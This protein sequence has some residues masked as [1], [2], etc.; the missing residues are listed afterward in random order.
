MII[1]RRYEFEYNNSIQDSQA[2]NPELYN[3]IR[4]KLPPML[5]KYNARCLG[6]SNKINETQKLRLVSREYLLDGGVMKVIMSRKGLERNML[7]EVG[8]PLGLK[9]VEFCNELENLIA[10][11]LDEA[12]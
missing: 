1:Y 2:G 3:M 9:A 6:I 5:T 7:I 4:Q 8:G 12:A 11:P 10:K